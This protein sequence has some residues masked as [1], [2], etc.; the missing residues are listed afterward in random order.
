MIAATDTFTGSFS[1]CR[2][3]ISSVSFNWSNPSGQMKP[4]D[5]TSI[6]MRSASKLFPL[7][8]SNIYIMILR[9]LPVVCLLKVTFKGTVS[10]MMVACRFTSLKTTIPGQRSVV[11][12]VGGKV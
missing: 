9:L 10:S 4:R 2:R 11:A 8:S 12:S 6:V 3:E 1:I 5:P 7:I